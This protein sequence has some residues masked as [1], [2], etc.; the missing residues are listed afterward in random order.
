MTMRLNEFFVSIQ[1]EGT[2]AGQPCAFVRF[3]ACNLRC[4]YCDTEYAFYEG[5]DWEREA[6]V[7][8]VVEAGIPMVCV[9]GG[10][11]MLQEEI[12]PF[13]QDLLDAGLEVLLETGGS[14]NCADVPDQ[15]IKIV[16][17]KT[18]GAM[19]AEADS[20]YAESEAFRRLH[21]CYEN[22]ESLRL[23]DELKFVLTGRADYE[24]ACSFIDEHDL[25]QKVS[26]ILMSPE[27]TSVSPK[28]LA[29]WILED[30]L[31]VRLNLQVHKYI[32]GSDAR[33]V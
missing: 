13:L 33:G 24:W 20:A 17:I 9:T 32:W 3:T 30:G 5:D 18:P 23:N 14:K 22:L 6:L 10:E 2:R 28:D 19:K 26:V 15:V 29:A 25:F 7:L 31:P 8:K 1:G 12:I 16:D 21:F 11:P 27:H 4:T